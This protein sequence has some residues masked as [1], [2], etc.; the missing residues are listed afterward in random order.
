MLADLKT[1]LVGVFHITHEICY[2]L[3][4]VAGRWWRVGW[5]GLKIFLHKISLLLN[6]PLLAIIIY[7]LDQNMCLE[8]T[9]IQICFVGV[10]KHS[11]S[12]DGMHVKDTTAHC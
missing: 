8:A 4:A 12:R 1:W 3:I 2:K 6:F 10:I 7:T 11:S 9:D 5:G